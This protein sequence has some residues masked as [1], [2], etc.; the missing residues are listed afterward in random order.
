MNSTCPKTRAVPF[1]T[2]QLLALGLKSRTQL[3]QWTSPWTWPNKKGRSDLPFS[4]EVIFL[5]PKSLSSQGSSLAPKSGS[6]FHPGLGQIKKAEHQRLLSKERSQKCSAF[7]KKQALSEDDLSSWQDKSSS[8]KGW[9]SIDR[10]MV[11]ALPSTTPRP[12]HKSSTDDLGPPL[13]Q[14]NEEERLSAL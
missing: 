2:P 8:Q 11:A 14:V 9:V 5:T 7:F 10:S 13:C 12:A 6:G 1:L 4:R 3:G